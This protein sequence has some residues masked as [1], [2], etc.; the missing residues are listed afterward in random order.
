MISFLIFIICFL[1]ALGWS[2]SLRENIITRSEKDKYGDSEATL[3]MKP[4]FVP[5]AI[6]VTGIIISLVQ[7][8]TWTRI[9]AGH[10]GIKVNLTGGERGVSKYEYKTGYVVYNTWFEQIFEFPTYQQHIEYDTIKVISKGGFM[11]DIRPSFNYSMIPDAVGDMFQNLRKPTNE[12]EQGWLK[13]A[14]YSS[15]NDVA[16]RWTVDSIFNHR[17]EF[18]SCIIVECNKRVS[19]WFVV[20][21]L[22]SNIVPPLALQESINKKTKAIQDVQVAENDKK[23]A[24]ARGETNVATAELNAKTM[25]AKARGDS[26]SSVIT[27][28]GDAQSIKVKQMTLSQMYIDYIK[29]SNWNGVLPGTVLGSSTPMISIK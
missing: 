3:N 14:I 9:D 18:E 8:Y 25:I 5:I 29:A 20:S 23:V 21:Q 6:L 26:A 24:I 2:L 13:N 15:V 19:K 4:L 22:R 1:V 10:V 28:Q 16:N 27:A 11:A 12:I 17:E 7:P